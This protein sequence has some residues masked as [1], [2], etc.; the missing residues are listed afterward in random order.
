MSST[1]KKKNS[2][3]NKEK[4]ENLT[5]NFGEYDFGFVMPQN[6]QKSVHK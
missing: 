4:E 5:P 1:V 6:S 2:S 3:H